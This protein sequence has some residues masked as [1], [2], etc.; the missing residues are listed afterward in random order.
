MHGQNL[1]H[2][3]QLKDNLAFDKDI[4]AVSRINCQI[5]VADW[6]KDLPPHRQAGAPNL[7]RKAM[8]ISTLEQSRPERGSAP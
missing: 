7:V 6:K 4:D 2:R 1:L 5:V 3:L 8:L